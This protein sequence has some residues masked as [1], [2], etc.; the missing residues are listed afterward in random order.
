MNEK[1]WKESCT[2][3]IFL[4]RRRRK[5]FHVHGESSGAGVWEVARSDREAREVSGENL[6]VY[7]VET[8]RKHI[9]LR[10]S[11]TNLE[12]PQYSNTSD[13]RVCV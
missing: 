9:E 10:V 13:S 2:N 1:R 4:K 8:N 6:R 11:V 7:D 5:S 12:Q 3:A